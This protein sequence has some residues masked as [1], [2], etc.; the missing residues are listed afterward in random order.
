MAT[1]ASGDTVMTP[2][3]AQDR[4]ERDVR[5]E[6][7]LPVVE[8]GAHLA[9]HCLLRVVHGIHQRLE[10][11]AGIGRVRAGDVA[12]ITGMAGAGVD[13]E[14]VQPAVAAPDRSPC[15]AAPRHA[16]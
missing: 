11:V 13:E 4:G 12:G 16:G 7:Q 3:V 5:V 2:A 1:A 9:A 14:A 10:L 15:N 8:A 6:V